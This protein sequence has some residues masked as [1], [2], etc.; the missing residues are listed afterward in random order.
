MVGWVSDILKWYSKISFEYIKI[1]VIPQPIHLIDDFSQ[2]INAYLSKCQSVHPVSA[3]WNGL[4]QHD[5][6]GMRPHCKIDVVTKKKQIYNTNYTNYAYI[7]FK[8]TNTRIIINYNN[9]Y[10][11]ANDAPNMYERSRTYGLSI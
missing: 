10:F 4:V 6:D 1:L 5:D 3:T 11:T 8:C 9:A 7:Y 2:L